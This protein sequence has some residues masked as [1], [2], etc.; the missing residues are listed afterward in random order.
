MRPAPSRAGSERSWT[1]SRTPAPAQR[2]AGGLRAGTRGDPC[3]EPTSHTLVCTGVSRTT[4]RGP[5]PVATRPRGESGAGS[6]GSGGR[7]PPVACPVT[8]ASSLLP[9][10]PLVLEERLRPIHKNRPSSTNRPAN[11]TSRLGEAW[12]N[13]GCP[14]G[15]RTHSPTVAGR[16]HGPA[17]PRRPDLRYSSTAPRA[18]GAERE[19]MI[20]WAV[21]AIVLVV[22]VAGGFVGRSRRNATREQNVRN[23][24]HATSHHGK[25]AHHSRGAAGATEPGGAELRSA[26]GPAVPGRCRTGSAAG[27]QHRTP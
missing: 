10:L 9:V 16:R 24:S 6:G 1:R 18:A 4:R 2:L 13:V 5:P 11:G 20:I 21:M 25:G 3:M 23:A 15:D 27:R 7:R 12:A 8:G 17:E 22:I 19:S 26:A 14:P